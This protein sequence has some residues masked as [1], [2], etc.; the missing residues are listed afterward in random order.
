MGVTD[1][2][3]D[4]STITKASPAVVTTSTA[5]NLSSNQFVRLTNMGEAGN[6]S[7]GMDSLVNG[8][9]KIKVI[10]STSFSLH[11]PYTNENIDTS[12]QKTYVSNGQSN[13]IQFDFIYNSN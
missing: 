9:F 2:K 6:H 5:H 3:R 8:R 1:Y 11:D 7:Y 4:I 12:N 13:L 10:D